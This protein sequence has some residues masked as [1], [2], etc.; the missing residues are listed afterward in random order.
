MLA[1]KAC[2]A[3]TPLGSDGHAL[4]SARS[5]P[6]MSRLPSLGAGRGSP[7]VAPEG[8]TPC[9]FAPRRD[10]AADLAAPG[11]GNCPDACPPR[12]PATAAVAPPPTLTPAAMRVA[13]AFK[14]AVKLRAVPQAAVA[15]SSACAFTT[16]A[17]TGSPYS[18]RHPGHRPPHCS[19]TCP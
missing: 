13:G 4:S 5:P 11:G 10:D 1:R 3:C 8:S 2:L 14:A 15:R 7:H 12:A 16:A 19:L 17:S 18:R 6:A 9:S